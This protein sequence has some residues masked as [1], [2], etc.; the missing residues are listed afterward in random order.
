MTEQAVANE[1]T[2]SAEVSAVAAFRSV[3]AALAEEQDLDAV[4]HL[5]VMKLSELTGAGRCSMH[6]LNRET[7]LF[8]GQ[9]AHA[10]TDIDSAV[11]QL[12]SGG[13]GDEFTREIVRTRR[14]VMV[15]NTMVDPRPLQVAMRR[16]HAKSVLGVPMILRDEVIGVLCLDSEDVTVEFSEHDQELVMTFAELAATAVNQ[17]Q[18]TTRLR[19]SLAT[20]SEQLA[21]LQQAARMESQLTDILLRGWGIR[22]LAE[23]V[24]RLLSKPCWIYDAEFNCLAQANLPAGAVRMLDESLRRS[25]MV[26]EL[27]DD[28]RPGHPRTL[29]RLPKMGLCHRL[30]VAQVSI[31]NESWGYVVVA[32][33]P[34]RFGPLDGAIVRRAA[35]NISL[36]RARARRDS[37]IEWHAVE[38]FTGSL[39]RG[40][41]VAIDA[42]AQG[43]GIDLTAP[44][45]VCLVG[46]RD[47]GAPQ[48]LTPKGLARLMTAS[49]A[50]S[51][52]LATPSGNDV[53]LVI[54]L[55]R[56]LTE[57]GATAWVRTQA[58]SM[59]TTLQHPEQLFVSISTLVHAPGDDVSA[60]RQ[61]Q[62]VLQ[63]MRAHA[64][65]AG[66]LTLAASDL[67]AGRLLLASADH[68]D[69]QRFAQETLGTLLSVSVT[70]QEELLS[71]LNAFLQTGRGVRR[72]AD[73]LAVHP[74]TVRY[75][76]ANI[77]KMTG[78]AITTDDDA[79][80]AAQMAVLVW[81][82]SGRLPLLP[83]V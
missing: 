60:H 11:R 46:R 4:L 66:N 80:I 3:T 35:H 42:R 73:L 21:M 5:I 67:G 52:V 24:S 78:L 76:V 36:E 9:V 75:R 10:A 77:E 41:Q 83:L 25:A 72:T 20:E 6:L 70:K 53:A 71:T 37:D 44:R 61:A 14:P 79:Y 15:V 19:A 54:E 55:P 13:P 8:H 28:L 7:G 62:Q 69:A 18:L 17:V 32:E 29:G 38:A 48:D 59:L 74:N 2:V 81:R 23:T 43:L 22:E 31:E 16:W 65:T 68:E 30:M 45:M 64:E 49:D 82:M 40:E 47:E 26:V 58:E 56:A 33:T 39:I 1:A 12:V 50:P 27:L 34:G 63:A 51:A 57:A